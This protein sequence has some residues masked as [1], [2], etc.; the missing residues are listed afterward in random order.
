MIKIC[1]LTHHY[2]FSDKQTNIYYINKLLS[3]FGYEVDWVTYPVSLSIFRHRNHYKRKAWVKGL[4]RQWYL[5]SLLPKF[6]FKSKI[7]KALMFVIPSKIFNKNYDILINEGLHGYYICDLFKYKKLVIRMSDDI[8]YLDKFSD[9]E[10]MEE[11]IVKK[12][13]QIWAA[14]KITADRYDNATFLPNPAQ[15]KNVLNESQRLNEVVYVGSNKIDTKLVYRIAASGIKVNLFTETQTV[16]HSNIIFHGL[17]NK[18]ELVQRISK[19]KVGIIPFFQDEHNKFMEM[20][21]KTFDYVAAGLHIV[22]ITSS[23]IIGNNIINVVD[24]YDDFLNE[25]NKSMLKNIDQNMYLNFLKNNSMEKFSKE[26]YSLINKL[27]V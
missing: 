13:N 8:R 14:H 20:P 18:K 24:N 27:N 21:L 19:Y 5:Y 3:D 1:I 11:K 10:L 4:K 16:Y 9:E 26:I 6:V 7:L 23:Q 12:A 2:K 15:Q 25:I 22:M 17:V